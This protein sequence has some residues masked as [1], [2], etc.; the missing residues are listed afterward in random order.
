MEFR[1]VEPYKHSPIFVDRTIV[2]RHYIYARSPSD[3]DDTEV[4]YSFPDDDP[5][6]SLVIKLTIDISENHPLSLKQSS[7]L[8][9]IPQ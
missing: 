7:R 4:V 6:I 8:N 3:A 2:I 9:E 5:Y 1:L